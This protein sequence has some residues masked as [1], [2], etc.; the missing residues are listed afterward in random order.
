MSMQY[1]NICNRD[2]D[3]DVDVDHF[4]ICHECGHELVTKNEYRDGVCEACNELEQAN[5]YKEGIR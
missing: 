5:N 2:I 3:L 1:Y 4:S